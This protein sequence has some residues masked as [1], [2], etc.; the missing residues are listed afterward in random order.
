[1][2]GEEWEDREDSEPEPEGSVGRIINLAKVFVSFNPDVVI[3]SGRAYFENP[4]F[5]G[6]YH[7]FFGDFPEIAEYTYTSSY[8]TDSIQSVPSHNAIYGHITQEELTLTSVS[9]SIEIFDSNDAQNYTISQ[10]NLFNSTL[11]LNRNVSVTAG[12][13]TDSLIT[14]VGNASE[15]IISYDQGGERVPWVTF[16]Q[17]LF[18]GISIESI[19]T[20]RNTRQPSSGNGTLQTLLTIQS[21]VLVVEGQLVSDSPSE[22]HGG[23]LGIVPQNMDTNARILLLNGAFIQIQPRG[24]LAI[25]TET[26]IEAASDDAPAVRNYGSVALVGRTKVANFTSGGKLEKAPVSKLAALG[27]LA[28][29]LAVLGRFDQDAEGSVTIYLNRTTQ[30]QPVLFL[31]S[32]RNF[33]G[34][35]NLDFYTNVAAGVYPDLLLPSYQDSGPSR[36]TVI[37]FRDRFSESERVGFNSLTVDTVAGLAFSQGVGSIDTQ[38]DTADRSLSAH[39]ASNISTLYS[40]DV[41]I[42]NIACDQVNT[43]YL[44]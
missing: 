37:A 33:S 4:S 6:R 31:V 25:L 20:N 38:T 3:T 34:T 15:G 26:F 24:T 36:W 23:R 35:V 22:N 12:F 1:M 42:Q 11:Q 7:I 8:V 18:T 13:I 27:S 14:S 41:Q 5:F 10:L 32:S 29:R 39:L 9:A 28:S 44:G 43:Y 2:G 17:S 19:V 40:W 16:L 21:C 30:S